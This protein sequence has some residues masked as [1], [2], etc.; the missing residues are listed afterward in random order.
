VLTA[1]ALRS[2]ELTAEWVA[3][4]ALVLLLV[5]AVRTWL[6]L[7]AAPQPMSRPTQPAD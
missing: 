1:F 2:I 5:S 7:S 6:G 3:A 4:I